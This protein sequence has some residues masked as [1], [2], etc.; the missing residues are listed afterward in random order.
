MVDVNE[1]YISKKWEQ[2]VGHVDFT[3]RSARPTCVAV[4]WWVTIYAAPF[5]AVCSSNKDATLGCK[6]Q[7]T[8]SVVMVVAETAVW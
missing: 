1:Y 4:L 3:A 5:V 2:F 8:A 7:A 6:L